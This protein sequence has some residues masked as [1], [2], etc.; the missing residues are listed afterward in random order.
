MRKKE[1]KQK[2]IGLDNKIESKNHTKEEKEFAKI[3]YNSYKLCQVLFPFKTLLA[4]S[5]LSLIKLIKLSF[6]I[7]FT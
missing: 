4:S 5:G 6:D 7:F 3:S 1:L 2:L